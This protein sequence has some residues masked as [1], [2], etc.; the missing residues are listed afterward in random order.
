VQQLLQTIIHQELQ[1]K[2]Y[3]LRSMISEKPN[4]DKKDAK[5]ISEKKNLSWV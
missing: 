1:I 4:K 2:K 3:K 5:L